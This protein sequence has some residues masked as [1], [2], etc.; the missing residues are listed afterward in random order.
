M[1]NNY[2]WLILSG[3]VIF[4]IG[5]IVGKIFDIPVITIDKNINPLH[6]LSILITLLVAIF[7]SV[8][9][10]KN[11]DI[12]N[13][14]NSIVIKRID[15]I[16]EILDSL[17]ELILDGSIEIGKAPSISKRVYSSLKC[18]FASFAEN[19]ISISIDFKLVEEK[20]RK[21]KD[22]LT[23]TPA[24]NNSDGNNASPPIKV[25]KKKYVYNSDRVSEIEKEVEDLK[26]DLFKAQLE[27]NKSFRPSL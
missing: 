17:N 26:N 15:K 25:D 22:L 27:I 16:I 23:N 19:N 24:L 21:I 20:N 6:A 18:V 11:K 2:F 4:L 7:I 13:A 10:Q 3:F 12:N 9:F 5:F 14:A 1:K 8:L